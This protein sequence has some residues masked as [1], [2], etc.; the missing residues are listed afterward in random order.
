MCGCASVGVLGS[1]LGVASL[2]W[3]GSWS[4]HRARITSRDLDISTLLLYADA[5][6][7]ALEQCVV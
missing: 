4:A 3:C 6:H 5:Q 1:Q 7:I 2:P